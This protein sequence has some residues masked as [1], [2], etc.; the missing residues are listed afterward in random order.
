MC[1]AVENDP[2]P[3]SRLAGGST[4]EA[5][6]NITAAMFAAYLK[7]RTKGYLTARKEN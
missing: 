6:A 3:K 4:M 1:A 2:L 5:G 7:C